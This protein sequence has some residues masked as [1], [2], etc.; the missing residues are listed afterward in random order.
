[1]EHLEST[2]LS[3]RQQSRQLVRE[4]D[5]I[6]GVFQ[7]TGYT[8]SQCHILFELEQH[9]RLSLMELSDLLLLDKSNTSRTVKKLLTLDLIKMEKSASDN[10]QKFFSVTTKGKKVI[11]NNNCLANEQVANALD[12]LNSTQQEQIITGLQLYAKALNKSRRQK[13]FKFRPI[14]KKDNLQ[15]A[16]VI[17]EVMTEYQAVGEGYSIM[18]PEVDDMYGFY[19][20]KQSCFYVIELNGEVVGGGGIAPLAGGDPEVCELRKMY[21]LPSTRGLGLGKKMLLLMLDKA[22]EKGFKVCYLETLDRMWRAN[23]LYSNN[24]FKAL[25]KPMG[26]T[27]HCGCDRW[28]AFDL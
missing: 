8:Y 23:Q 25:K 21:F 2:I 4:L 3:I 9:G 24:G 19:K 17:R 15:M 13:S 5:F 14:Q 6:K 28:Y 16:R 12:T 20:N 10:R 7:N 26:N 22:R 1:M 27:G 18:D 11:K